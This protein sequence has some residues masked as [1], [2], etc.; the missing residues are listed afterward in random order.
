LYEKPG[1]SEEELVRRLSKLNNDGRIGLAVISNGVINPISD[2]NNANFPGDDN[3]KDRLAKFK[4]TLDP[5]WIEGI[6]FYGYY[7]R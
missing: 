1:W 5:T 7:F 2:M 3:I 6:I 4:Q